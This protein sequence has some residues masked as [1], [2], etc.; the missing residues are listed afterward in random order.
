[1][2]DDGN[3]SDAAAKA[4]A[5]AAAK[6]TDDAS[7]KVAAAKLARDA[8]NAASAAANDAVDKATADPTDAAA[9]AAAEVATNEAAAKA[10][11][12]KTAEDA[13][14]AAEMDAADKAAAAKD[15]ADA[16]AADTAANTASA[17]QGAAREASARDVAAPVLVTAPVS[18]SYLD[19]LKAVVTDQGLSGEDK[20]LVL[21]QLK[22]MSPTSD[23]LTYRTAI[24]I[25]GV[26]ALLTI[27]AIWHLSAK[28]A[29]VTIP[30]GLIAIASGAV[31]GLAGLLS[32]PRNSEAR[33][34]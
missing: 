22:G 3:L 11:A 14:N 25:L 1:M 10:T 2:A 9:K 7:T 19:L 34:P 24:L 28:G 15:L 29:A 18:T 21:L 23:R 16:A 20:K 31:G 27:V 8:S 26:I 33:T 17:K 5:D 13:A 32:P 4:A 12:A 30:D 6:A